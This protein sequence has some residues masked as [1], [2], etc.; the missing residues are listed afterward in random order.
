MKR[1]TWVALLGL[2]RHNPHGLQFSSARISA[3]HNGVRPCRPSANGVLP[4]IIIPRTAV[5]GIWE[6]DV[7]A[8]QAL[9]AAENTSLCRRY[10]AETSREIASAHVIRSITRS[11]HDSNLTPY[12]QHCTNF[13]LPPAETKAEGTN[14]NA[15]SRANCPSGKRVEW[16]GSEGRD[17]QAGNFINQTFNLN[18]R[19]YLTEI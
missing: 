1:E 9:S 14:P 2:K 11:N 18:R 8:T 19:G 5:C 15:K 3:L 10:N 6:G 17:L 4:C 7:P 13:F 16:T 12:F